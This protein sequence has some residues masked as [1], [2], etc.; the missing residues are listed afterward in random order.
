MPNTEDLIRQALRDR[1]ATVTPESLRYP[2]LDERERGRR[3]GS[4]RRSLLRRPW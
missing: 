4:C 1:A 2:E 3:A